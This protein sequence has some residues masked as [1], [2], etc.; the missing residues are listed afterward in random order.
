M[1]DQ[2]NDKPI[3]VKKIIDGGHGHH[4]GAW[5]VAYADFVTAMMALF[6]VLWILGQDQ[7]VKENIAGYFNDPSGFGVGNGPSAIEGKGKQQMIPSPLT[8]LQKKEIEK[9]RLESMGE[10][11]LDNLKNQ[12]FKELIDQ[13]DIEVTDEGLRIEIMESSNDAFFEVGTSILSEK[14]KSILSIIGKQMIQV[15]NKIVVEGHTDSRP[16]SNGQDGYSNYELSADRANSARRIL[17]SSGLKNDQIDEIRGYADNR[18]RNV[19]DP[20]DVVNRR[21]SIIVKYSQ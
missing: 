21:I 16:F 1:A 4:G 8:D 7:A 5:K 20:N 3:I 14:A 10:E 9:E 18:L 15:N 2:G 13:I 11:L 6:I 19:N 17:L 12:D